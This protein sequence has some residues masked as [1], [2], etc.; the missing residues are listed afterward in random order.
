LKQISAIVGEEAADAFVTYSELSKDI[1]PAGII[2]KDPK[3]A[4]IPDPNRVDISWATVTGLLYYMNDLEAAKAAFVYAD[5]LPADVA[6]HLATNVLDLAKRAHG[7]KG[8]MALSQ[9]LNDCGFW[10]ENS[11]LTRKLHAFVQANNGA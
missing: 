7:F 2:L 9:S 6:I 11:V 5:R 1:I 8:V 4:P 10:K 3:G